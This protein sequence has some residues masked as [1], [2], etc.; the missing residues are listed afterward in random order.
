MAY[1]PLNDL[2]IEV[3][4]PAKKELFDKIQNNSDD[5]ETRIS[6]VELAT[7]KF[8]IFTGVID[9][10]FNRV[11]ELKHFLVSSQ[12]DINNRIGPDWV[13]RIDGSSLA[14]TDLDSIYTYSGS[15]PN[16]KTNSRFLRYSDT[17]GYVGTEVASS[18]KAHIHNLEEIS[19]TTA[20][21]TSESKILTAPRQD[22]DFFSGY[23]DVDPAIGRSKTE[24]EFEARPECCAVRMGVR[25]N[26]RPLNYIKVAQAPA[27]LNIVN[28][29]ISN[30]EAGTSGNLTVDINKGTDIGAV[31]SILNSPLSIAYS[32]GNYATSVQASFST[33]SLLQND[34]ITLDITSMQA[35]QTRFAISCY[36]EVV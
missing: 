31:A 22:L 12:V 24:G 2:E 18:N 16:F 7:G 6:N 23:I 3:G 15:L 29:T 33:S 36:A 5:H 4:R 34:F 9:V 21:G 19:H 14:G 32:A 25:V 26:D 1:D 10:G 13:T 35:G 8:V 28:C 17:S 20:T 30:L 11:G 27:N